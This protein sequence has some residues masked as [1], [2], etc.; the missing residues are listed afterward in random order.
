MITVIDLSTAAISANATICQG[1]SATVTFTGTP[2][3]VVSYTVNGAPQ[4]IT[5]GASGTA[6]ITQVYTSTT[7]YQLLSV[8]TPGAPGCTRNVPGTVLIT[9]VPP[10]TAAISANATICPGTSATVNFTGTPNAIVSYTVNGGPIQ[11]ITLSAAGIASITAVY[12]VTTTFQL[13]S[14]STP[15]PDSCTQN[16][17][18]TVTITVLELPVVSINSNATVCPGA[19]ATITFNGTPGA[20]VTYTVNSGSNQT[21]VLNASGI[22]TIT[23]NYTATTVYALVSVSNPA[24]QTCTQPAAGTVT[25]AV[26]PA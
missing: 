1:Q 12:T 2:N 23:Q 26:I 24:A 4:T 17:A 20:V 14:V 7:T 18:G 19:S 21:I 25:L 10:P 22:G 13:V 5:L 9:V 15:L 11:T 8:T 16:I 6:T 3:A